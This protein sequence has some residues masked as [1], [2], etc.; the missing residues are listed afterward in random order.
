[1]FIVF[2]LFLLCKA[3]VFW[4]VLSQIHGRSPATLSTDERDNFNIDNE[5]RPMSAIGI[6]IHCE[7]IRCLCDSQVPPFVGRKMCK[8]LA[9]LGISVNNTKTKTTAFSSHCIHEQI[10]SCVKS[11]P[12]MLLAVEPVVAIEI[13]PMS[14]RTLATVRIKGR[15]G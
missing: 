5:V 2:D 1:M 15:Q 9:H 7:L 11:P 10:M 6:V 13:Q 3:R 14:T 12:S 4:L 8:L